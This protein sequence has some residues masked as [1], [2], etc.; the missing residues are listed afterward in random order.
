[1]T[2]LPSD[3]DGLKL[4][5]SFTRQKPI[6]VMDQGYPESISAYKQI[7]EAGIL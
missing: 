3:A 7:L 5:L 1:L 4:I 6:K 2:E